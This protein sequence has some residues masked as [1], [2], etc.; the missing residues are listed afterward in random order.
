MSVHSFVP[1]KDS[2]DGTGEIDVMLFDCFGNQNV[3]M[4]IED[5]I[6]DVSVDTALSERLIYAAGKNDKYM[7][8]VVIGFNGHEIALKVRVRD[9][10]QDLYLNGERINGFIGP[11]ILKLIYRYPDYNVFEFDVSIFT[12]RE[13]HKILENLR[14]IYRNIS[15]LLA[16]NENARIDFTIAYVALKMITEK[17]NIEYQGSSYGWEDFDKPA[18]INAAVDAIKKS[19]RYDKYKD[20]FTI[21]YNKKTNKVSFDFAETISEIDV[22][23]VQAIHAEISKIP[24]MHAL[25]IDLF[26]EVYEVLANKK[27]FRRILYQETY[28]QTII[29]YFYK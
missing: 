23:T 4:V 12:Q 2:A 28:N 14:I 3:D 25:P 29:K 20:I 16:D 26:G 7:S 13:F 6:A 22:K 24:V 1:S 5:K 17:E 21:V 18:K 8:R 11:E 15:G 27:G 10:W 9:T 19:D